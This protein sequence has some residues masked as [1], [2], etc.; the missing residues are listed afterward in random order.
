MNFKKIFLCWVFGLKS[1]ELFAQCCAGGS[2]SPIAGGAS[3]GVLLEHQVDINSNFQHIST[4]KF[5]T[6]SSLAKNPENFFKSYKSNYIYNRLGYGITKNFTMYVETGYFINKTELGFEPERTYKSKGIGDL[7]LFPRYDIINKTKKNKRTELTLGLG[8]KIPLGKYNDSVSREVFGQEDIYITKPLSV[9][10]TSGAH[11]IIFY[12]FFLKDL[13][14]FKVFANALYIQKGWN[15]LGEK[16]GDFYTIGLFASKT[17]FKNLGVTLQVRGEIINKMKLNKNILLYAYPNYDPFATGSKKV[18]FVPQLS[19]SFQRKIT[20]FA[21]T[22]IPIYQYVTNTQ[23]ASQYQA[24]F[25]VSYRF[26]AFESSG[27]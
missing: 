14:N 20:V 7:I 26:M 5:L 17:F 22:E 8:F 19:Y 6:G 27:D 3:Q 12:S 15:P 13:S 21:S 1:F 10:P 9:Q 24:T 18:F 4:T 2:G 11:D 25:G 16:Q 23:I